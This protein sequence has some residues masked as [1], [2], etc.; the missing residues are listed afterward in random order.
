MKTYFTADPHFG[1]VNMTQEGRDLCNRG[2]A[3][4]DEMNETLLD[5]INSTVTKNDRLVILGDIIMGPIE[6]NISLL[7]QIRAAE[8]VL[9][10]GNHDR[11]SPAYHH[12]GGDVDAK[13]EQWRQRYAAAHCNAVALH[14]VD[15]GPVRYWEFCQLSDEWVKHPLDKAIYSHF[16]YQGD[17]TSD[18]RYVELRPEDDGKTPVIHGHVHDSWRINGRQFNVGVDVNDFKPVFED[19]L[20]DWVQSL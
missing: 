10:P 3:T 5:G 1:H 4:V 7:A 20:A 6:K 16:P 17:H 8:V 14:G 9:V 13:R 18:D 11:W 2:F 12:K 19:E 15:E